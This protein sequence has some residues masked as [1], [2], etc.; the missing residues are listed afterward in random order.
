[1]ASSLLRPTPLLSTPHKL[2]H[3]HTSL[4]FPSEIST[5][6]NPH[7]HLL[8]LCRSSSTPSQQKTSQRKRTRY[9]KQYPGE[10]IGITE[11]MRFVAMRLRNVNGKKLDLSGD[12][13]EQEEEEDEV[14]EETWKPSKEGFLKYLVDSKLVFDTIERIVDESENVS[15]AYFRRTGLERCESLEKD[16]QWFR[17]QDLVIPEPSNIGV[18]YAKYLE[19]QAGQ[20]APLF[21][22]HFYSIYFSHIAGGQ[23]IVRQVSEKLLEGKELDFNR[24]EGDAQDLLKGVREKLNVLGEH[25]TRDEKNK[26]LK[27]TAKAFK[28][29]GQIVRLII[30]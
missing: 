10:N 24:W 16:L 28:Y 6:R 3:L 4:S 27:E 18:S 7:N 9:R 29:M 22:S 12:K 23:V 2:S 8:N 19:E 25:W 26:C 13:T 1:M 5:Q 11:E 15:Y 21:L 14:K 20:S 17:G 30:L